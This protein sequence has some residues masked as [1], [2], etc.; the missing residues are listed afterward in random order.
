MDVTHVTCQSVTYVCL[1]SKL[2]NQVGRN[3]IPLGIV[4]ELGEPLD[5]LALIPA[6]HIFRKGNRL[7]GKREVRHAK[8]GVGIEHEM[9]HGR[10]HRRE[11]NR[12]FLQVVI[13]IRVVF[14]GK[15]VNQ[16]PDEF[17]ALG[18]A[19]S[20][21]SATNNTVAADTVAV[22]ASALAR[23]GTNLAPLS[24]DILRNVVTAAL[25]TR[26]VI[27]GYFHAVGRRMKLPW[28]PTGIASG[29][30][31]RAGRSRGMFL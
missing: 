27:A 14:A 8:A 23:F 7:V 19:A 30:W 6:Q 17:L 11:Q 10:A 29:S 9:R 1:Y 25:Q 2:C 4:V 24:D 22:L 13:D 21:G 31:Q 28:V 16:I 15:R 18:L 20:K 12:V 5:S 26:R 3:M